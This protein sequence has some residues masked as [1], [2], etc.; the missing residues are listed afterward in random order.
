MW[1]RNISFKLINKLVMRPRYSRPSGSRFWRTWRI[2]RRDI[3][4]GA[5]TGYVAPGGG[6]D[7]TVDLALA[8][9]RAFYVVLPW[10]QQ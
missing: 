7:M 4:C 1:K 9:W 6:I 8:G 2:R 10:V 3:R 5:A